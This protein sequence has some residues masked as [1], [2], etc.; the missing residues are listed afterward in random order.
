M[1]NFDIIDKINEK[2]MRRF[3][4]CFGWWSE[5]IRPDFY[6]LARQNIAKSDLVGS[7]N[8]SYT[9]HVNRHEQE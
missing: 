5:I 9:K 1:D 8:S 2:S 4:S 3:G 6:K 7:I